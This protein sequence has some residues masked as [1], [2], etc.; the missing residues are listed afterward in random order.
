MSEPTLNE[1]YLTQELGSLEEAG[2]SL[3]G[4]CSQSLEKLWLAQALDLDRLRFGFFGSQ[5]PVIGI[6]V[7]S[8]WCSVLMAACY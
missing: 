5:V 4:P 3:W 7:A 6:R 1:T 8:M 2:R